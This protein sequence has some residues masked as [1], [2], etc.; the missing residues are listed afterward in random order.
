MLA[1]TTSLPI[2]NLTLSFLGE[3]E[4]QVIGEMGVRGCSGLFFRV[5]MG[6]LLLARYLNRVD[7]GVFFVFYE[8]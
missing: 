6:R 7:R 5:A 2:I 8:D 4:L 3:E 1:S